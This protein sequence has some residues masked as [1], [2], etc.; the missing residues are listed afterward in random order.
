MLVEGSVLAAAG[1][2]SGEVRDVRPEGFDRHPVWR[3]GR[4]FAIAYQ[5]AS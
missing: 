5:G 3:D 1:S 4:A 2:L